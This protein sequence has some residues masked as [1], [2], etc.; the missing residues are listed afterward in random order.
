MVH[1][2]YA[3]ASS[4]VQLTG[5]SGLYAGGQMDDNYLP[6]FLDLLARSGKYQLPVRIA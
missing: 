4:E 3:M 2:G 6:P 5:L 1:L